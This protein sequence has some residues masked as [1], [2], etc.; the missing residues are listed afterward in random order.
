[1]GHPGLGLLI[2]GC[3]TSPTL[4]TMKLSRRWGTRFGG[5]SNPTHDDGAVMYGAPGFR[6]VWR[7]EVTL[8][9]INAALRFALIMGHPGLWW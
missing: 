2:E 7:H 6:G 3:G 4:A 9:T 1:M 8:P 5:G